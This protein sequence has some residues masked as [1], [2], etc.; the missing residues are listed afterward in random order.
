MQYI[1]HVY[2]SCDFQ[3][4]LFVALFSVFAQVRPIS[5]SVLFPFSCVHRSFVDYKSPIYTDESCMYHSPG[6]FTAGQSDYIM[7]LGWTTAWI[8]DSNS[9]HYHKRTFDA[10]QSRVRN[11]GFVKKLIIII[12]RGV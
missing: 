11:D 5:A 3:L 9:N 8:V 12:G 7:Q 10:L 1:T 4:S 2:R 6:D